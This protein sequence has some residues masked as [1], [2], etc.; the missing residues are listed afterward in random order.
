MARTYWPPAQIHSEF[1][2]RCA[3]KPE[4]LVPP[5]VKMTL[6]TYLD[7]LLQSILVVQARTHPLCL[8]AIRHSKLEDE[9]PAGAALGD[10]SPIHERTDEG[11]V[12]TMHPMKTSQLIIFASRPW[13]LSYTHL[14]CGDPAIRTFRRSPPVHLLSDASPI[15]P[16]NPAQTHK[17]GVLRGRPVN[18]AQRAVAK[19][20]L[21]AW[22]SGT[23][24]C[25]HGG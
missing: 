8:G 24:I 11:P 4:C 1:A 18:L 3:P 9:T 21:V 2:P 6:T 10:T 22:Y 19:K 14:Q 13:T 12:V 17:R 16:V 15:G 7:P 20:V 5:D 25:F 23:H